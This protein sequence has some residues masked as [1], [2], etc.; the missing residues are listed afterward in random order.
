MARNDPFIPTALFDKLKAAA[1]L[2]MSVAS[3]VLIAWRWYRAKED[4]PAPE[5]ADGAVKACL[6]RVADID[7]ELTAGVDHAA[8]ADIATRLVEAK[9]EIMDLAT[10]A[11]LADPSLIRTA[12]LC[13]ADTRRELDAIA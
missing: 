9:R 5:L 12:L 1:G 13:I 11:K 6:A 3:A 7:R 10:G 4:P 8:V 2:A